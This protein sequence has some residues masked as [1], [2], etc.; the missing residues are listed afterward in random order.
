MGHLGWSVPPPRADS[1]RWHHH[2]PSVCQSSAC[3]LPCPQPMHFIRSIS[4]G[5]FHPPLTGMPPPLALSWA[6]HHPHTPG[7][8]GE[9]ISQFLH[10]SPTELLS[11]RNHMTSS[12]RGAEGLR[13]P[14]APA[15]ATQDPSG[16]GPSTFHVFSDAFSST[17]ALP[18]ILTP[19]PCLPHSFGPLHI[20]FALPRRPSPSFSSPPAARSQLLPSQLRRG[21]LQEVFWITTWLRLYTFLHAPTKSTSTT[22]CSKLSYLCLCIFSMGL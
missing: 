15:P 20:H 9:L 3:S 5:H 18:P 7:P 10:G 2:P 11:R 16:F 6:R 21:L 14:A 12:T 22:E 13:V 17:P 19:T 8:S 1:R 4:V